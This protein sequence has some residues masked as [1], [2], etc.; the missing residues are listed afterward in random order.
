MP[1]SLDQIINPQISPGTY[2]YFGTASAS[3]DKDFQSFTD[4]VAPLIEIDNSPGNQD[5]NQMG[6]VGSSAYIGSQ[7]VLNTVTLNKWMWSPT[8]GYWVT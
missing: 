3:G 8:L 4:I 6:L 1:A 7:W 2:R 5:P